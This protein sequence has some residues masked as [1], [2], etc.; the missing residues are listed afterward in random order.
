[1]T[2]RPSRTNCCKRG[3]TAVIS[4]V[5]SSTA[6]WARVTPTWCASAD[7][8]CIPGAPCFLDDDVTPQLKDLCETGPITVAHQGRTR[9]EIALLN[10]PMADVHGPRGVLPVTGWREC[11]D[12]CNI[13]PQPRLVLFDDHDI[14]PALVHDRLRDV[15]LGQEPG[16]FSSPGP[17]FVKGG[18][19]DLGGS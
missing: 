5:L 1:M 17:P 19:G 16:P 10:A 4:L 12:Q 11:K 14:I 9:R 13:G 6:C 18:W 8:R 3:S 15:A 2:I 7:N